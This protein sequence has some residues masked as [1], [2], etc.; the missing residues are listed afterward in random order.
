MPIPIRGN[1]PGDYRYHIYDYVNSVAFTDSPAMGRNN[2]IFHSL[3]ADL[4]QLAA[5]AANK[6]INANLNN[7][8]NSDG[9]RPIRC[10]VF[11]GNPAKKIAL[12]GGIHAREWIAVEIPYLAAEY[13]IENY[14]AA[15]A[16]ARER[17]IKALVDDREIWVVPMINPDGHMHSVTVDRMWRTNRRAMNVG[18]FTPARGWVTN[19]AIGPPSPVTKDV[20][21][22]GT[23]V[24]YLGP[25]RQV[26]IL[27]TDVFVGV[28]CNRNFPHPTWGIESYNDRRVAEMPA[29]QH[30]NNIGY[31]RTMSADPNDTLNYCG[32]EARSEPETRAVAGMFDAQSFMASIDFHSYSQL[33][34]YSDFARGDTFTKWVGGCM[35]ELVDTDTQRA[36]R[37]AAGQRRILGKRVIGIGNALVP[38]YRLGPTSMLYSASGSVMDYSYQKGPRPAY[39]IELDPANQHP[40]FLLPETQIRSTFEKN[41][42]AILAMIKCSSKDPRHGTNDVSRGA[43]RIGFAIKRPTNCCNTF[44]NWD[45]FGQGNQLP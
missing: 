20:T 12:T 21:Q 30:V 1:A 8:G 13:L 22:A 3:E 27:S 38:H 17:E 36:L 15:P 23:G 34:L 42:R 10:L 43:R 7:L 9:G 11:G 26:Q 31:A 4:A 41:I 37:Q 29:L 33:I 39:T 18:D 2:D 24:T 25:T 16:N 6:G 44:S 14:V 28:D 5:E 45:V 40:G 32:P 35:Q 19:H